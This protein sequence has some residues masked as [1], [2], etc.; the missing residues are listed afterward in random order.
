[1][2]EKLMLAPISRF[3]NTKNYMY[4]SVA[5]V[6]GFTGVMA[7]LIS[8]TPLRVINTP[9]ASIAETNVKQ[10]EASAPASSSDQTNASASTDTAVTSKPATGNS[11][12]TWPMPSTPTTTTPPAVTIPTVPTIPTEPIVPTVPVEPDPTPDPTPEPTPEPTPDPV[13]PIEIPI[14]VLPL[15]I[16]ENLEVSATLSI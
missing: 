2:K 5:V 4:G 10:K 1:M 11:A 3:R 9:F 8:I 6:A 14:P 7:L 13:L 15:P 12:A 16:I